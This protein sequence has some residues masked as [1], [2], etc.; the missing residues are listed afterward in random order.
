MKKKKKSDPE[1][2][3]SVWNQET[4]SDSPSVGELLRR[5]KSVSAMVDRVL[6]SGEFI[7]SHGYA[8]PPSWL[9]YLG[10]HPQLLSRHPWYK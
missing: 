2:P 5:Y 3:E 10:T 9:L 4:T 6:A 1:L 8:V 7:E